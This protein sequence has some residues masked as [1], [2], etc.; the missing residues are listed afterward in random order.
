MS[1]DVDRLELFDRATYTDANEA[2]F[3]TG[4]YPENLIEGFHLLG[5]LDHLS[6][7]V[8]TVE[9]PGLTGWNYG[10][11]LV[12]FT[13]PVEAGEQLR[14]I[15]VVGAVVPKGDG[16]QIRFDCQIEVAGTTKPALV[17][18]WWV[19]WMLADRGLGGASRGEHDP[20]V[21]GRSPGSE[22]VRGRTIP[23]GSRGDQS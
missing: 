18:Q 17:A 9:E 19:L 15:G 10:F 23:V 3:D 21:P 6:N 1:V 2:E 4:L 13:N 11:D 20:S 8:I 16:Y 5:L 14:L 7:G 22:T 12:R